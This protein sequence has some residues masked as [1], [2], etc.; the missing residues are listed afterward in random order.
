[1]MRL[2]SLFLFL[3][4][5][6]LLAA[7]GCGYFAVGE[8]DGLLAGRPVNVAI[9]ANRT[10]R[11]RLENVL[12]KS[13][14][15]EIARLSPASLVGEERAELILGGV[16]TSVATAPVSYSASDRVREYRLT[17]QTEAI[18]TERRSGKVVWKGTETGEAVYPVNQDLALQL[19]AEEAA[20]KEASRR[21]AERI[22][23]HLLEN[24]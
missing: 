13:M 17:L 14:R 24:F 18:L 20:L 21:L 6:F 3:A 7:G 19:N 5:V 2:K 23:R 11:P 1:M 10:T 9:F 4:A 8:R 15:W 12:A 22:V 16:V